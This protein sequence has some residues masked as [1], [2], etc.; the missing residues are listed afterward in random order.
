MSDSISDFITI[1]RNAYTAKKEQCTGK[2]SKLHAGI[3]RILAEE[4]FISA[5]R[6]EKNDSGQR[7]IT[8]DLKYVD[9]TPALAG[10]ERASKPGRRLYYKNDGIPRTLGGL[11]ISI[12]TT[13]R[14]LRTDQQ[15][16]RDRV[17]GEFV[18]KVW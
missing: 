4:G 1:I 17:G 5:W 7:F 12:V 15:C 10:I 11:G 13:S 2:Y 8:M 14:G 6:E 16:R 9:E 3:A 18:C